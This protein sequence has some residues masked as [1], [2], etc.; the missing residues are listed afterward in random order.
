MPTP[1]PRAATTTAAGLHG[2]LHPA[3]L[4]AAALSVA[5]GFAQFGVVAGLGDVAQ[6]FGEGAGGGVA[7]QLG[8][9][10]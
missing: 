5:S 1:P 10:A 7:D 4:A 3:V 2:W 6:A 9:S 8:L